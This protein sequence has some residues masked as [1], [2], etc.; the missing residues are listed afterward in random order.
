MKPLFV[1]LILASFCF[2]GCRSNTTPAYK[3]I[4][5]LTQC[6]RQEFVHQLEQ[7]D[8]VVTAELVSLQQGWVGASGSIAPSYQKASFKVKSVLKGQCQDKR[9]DVAFVILGCQE[10]EERSKRNPSLI[11]LSKWY[12]QKGKTF[13]VLANNALP[14]QFTADAPPWEA[15]QQNIDATR[16]IL[17]ETK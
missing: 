9:I 11:R 16:K 3:T 15:S 7:A 13:I 8:L 6:Q 4:A 2:I 10:G 1:P 5:N 12:Y 14:D 17:K